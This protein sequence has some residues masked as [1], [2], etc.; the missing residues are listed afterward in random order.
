MQ[1]YLT[2]NREG[3]NGT[4]FWRGDEVGSAHSSA[5]VSSL[6]CGRF[7]ATSKFQ[8]TFARRAFPCF[9][10]PSF[11]STFSTTLVRPSGDGYIAL[12]NMPAEVSVGPPTGL[13]EWARECQSL[14]GSGAAGGGGRAGLYS[15]SWA[16]LKF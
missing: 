7:I 8:P 15:D 11:K 4:S 10:E 6:V 12:S 14:R 9:D 3:C 2:A 16:G 13:W 5:D 1:K